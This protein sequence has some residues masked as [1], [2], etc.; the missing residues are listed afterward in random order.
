[1]N[2]P[3]NFE[4]KDGLLVGLDKSGNLTLQKGAKKI[5][6]FPKELKKLK[7]LLN[8]LSNK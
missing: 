4:G 8:N 7:G 6:V 1:M 2:A 5:T 3:E